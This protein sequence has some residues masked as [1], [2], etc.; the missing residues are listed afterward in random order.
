MHPDLS[1]KLANL[2]IQ[3]RQNIQ[4]SIVDQPT[5]HAL[6]PPPQRNPIAGHHNQRTNQ[7][8]LAQTGTPC[9]QHPR[10][11]LCKPTRHH[12]CPRPINQNLTRARGLNHH[13]DA[14]TTARANDSTFAESRH[15]AHHAG[16]RPERTT[17]VR[18]YC[19]KKHDMKSRSKTRIRTKS[20]VLNP[21]HP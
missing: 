10:M 9:P 20:A 19:K 14:A 11:T 8:S 5:V 1:L 4:Q 13:Q 15:D 16:H 6:Q 18:L 17:T 3:N 2:R 21:R 12:P 7:P